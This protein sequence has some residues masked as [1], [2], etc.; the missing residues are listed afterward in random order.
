[1]S[2]EVKDEAEGIV[3]AL[4]KDL[5]EKV[6]VAVIPADTRREVAEEF[7]GFLGKLVEFFEKNLPASAAKNAAILF[8]VN[9]LELDKVPRDTAF[10]TLTLI[11]AMKRHAKKARK[12]RAS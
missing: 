3:E 4:V 6:P 7:V 10:I 11:D 2:D 8:F 1:M 9:R 5:A 12:A